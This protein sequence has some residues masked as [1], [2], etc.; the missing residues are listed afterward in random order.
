MNILIVEDDERKLV[1]L[2]NFILEI[3]KDVNVQQCK[4]FNS[5]FR[6]LLK[7]EF[8]VVIL[9]MSLPTF[10]ITPQDSGGRPMAYGGRELLQKIEMRKI[11]TKV[12]LVT[13]FDHFGQEDSVISLSDLTS[14]LKE[15]FSD[16]FEDSVYYSGSSDDWKP[17]L[18]ELLVGDDYD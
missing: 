18:R 7:G 3:V 11:K 13:Q 16:V 4:S 14:D 2:N 9:D 10:D 8:E 6:A 12:I 1:Q 17:R 5:G 15:N